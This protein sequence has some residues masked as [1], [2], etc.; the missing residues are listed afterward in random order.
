VYDILVIGGGLAASMAAIAA[1]QNG[2][3]VA[4]VVKGKLAESGS[5]SKAAGV[6][7]AAFNHGVDQDGMQ[8]DS[9]GLHVADTLAV[10][11]ELSSE[12]HARALAEDAVDGI[13]ELERLGVTF[14]KTVDG[15][16]HQVK[17]VG[18]TRHRGCSVV[19]SGQALMQTLRERAIELG[20]TLIEQSVATKLLVHEGEV[21]GAR[22]RTVNGIEERTIAAKGTVVASGG[23]TGLFRTV[24]GDARNTGDGLAIAYEAGAELA[25]PEFVEFTLIFKVGER[26]LPI[27]GLS[28][29]VGRGARPINRLGEHF[30]EPRYTAEQLA[31]LGRAELLRAVVEEINAGRGPVYLECSQ[32]DET[33]WHEFEYSGAAFLSKLRE[34]GQDYRNDPIEVVPA[35]HSILFGLVTDADA[36]TSLH[37]LWAAGECAAGVH[38]AARLSG[39][40]LSAALVFGRRAGRAAAHATPLSSSLPEESS[41]MQS[42]AST[43]A[44]DLGALRDEVSRLAEAALGV[45]RDPQRLR[46]A[47]ERFKEIRSLLEACGDVS[48]QA[49]E[50]RH[51]ATLGELMAA[52]ALLRKESRGLHVRTDAAAADPHW[53][54]WLI[55]R[56]GSKGEPEWDYRDALTPLSKNSSS[57]LTNI[58]KSV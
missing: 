10:G 25:N 38:G 20:V 11:C 32:I 2:A 54:K 33:A 31:S 9:V 46:T 49:L 51:L 19:G 23:A 45:I 42:A 14:S 24:S 5:S 57:V 7:A 36:K 47:G 40:G 43:G 21:I 17:L 55:V 56:R 13:R 4:M 3:R 34:A 12:P 29:L 44:S 15:R 37:R 6:L 18:N 16:F 22:V 50:V 1:R 30:L 52:G 41:A 48:V 26:L 28:P 39:N 53:R 35:A 8:Q 58:S 27:A